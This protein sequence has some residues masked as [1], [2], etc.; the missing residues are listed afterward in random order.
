[1]TEM[2]ARDATEVPVQL[3][4]IK[5]IKEKVNE[6]K[7]SYAVILS[8]ETVWYL[9]SLLQFSFQSRFYNTSETSLKPS[10]GY[11]RKFVVRNLIPFLVF[12][13]AISK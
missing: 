12:A 4:V 3:Q 13:A 9:V 11:E 5:W 1:M 7:S 6:K 8:N 2:S 10:S